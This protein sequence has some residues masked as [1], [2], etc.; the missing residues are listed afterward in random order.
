MPLL[1]P[2][3]PIQNAL[4]GNNAIL[5]KAARPYNRSGK[6]NYLKRDSSEFRTNRFSKFSCPAAPI[7]HD[8]I[9]RPC[10]DMV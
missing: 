9:A 7:F 1:L 2:S 3:S 4:T 6:L 5:H 10:Q 8:L